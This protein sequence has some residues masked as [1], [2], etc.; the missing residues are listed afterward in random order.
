[1]AEYYADKGN[2]PAFLTAVG[3]T[4]AGKYVASMTIL[5]GA[6]SSGGLIV[7]ATFN[8]AGV[9]AGIRGSTYALETTDGGKTW[10]CGTNASSGTNLASKYLPGACKP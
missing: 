3:D 2:W 6:S 1:M 7:Q 5:S 8:S 9:N 10:N 4:T